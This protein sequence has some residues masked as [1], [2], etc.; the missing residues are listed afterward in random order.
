MKADCI[1]ALGPKPGLA[2]GAACGCTVGLG[3]GCKMPLTGDIGRV[4]DAP[5]V[6]WPAGIWVTTPLRVMV[7][8]LFL[9]GVG[10]GMGMGWNYYVVGGASNGRQNAI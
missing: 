5:A 4:K 6:G 1:S 2:A 9:R 7:P 8:P 10:S 3:V